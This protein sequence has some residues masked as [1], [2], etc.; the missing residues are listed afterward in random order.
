M[1]AKG[2]LSSM[3]NT[4]TILISSIIIGGSLI[5]S[6][7]IMK[8]LYPFENEHVITTTRGEVK[9]GDIYSENRLLTIRLSDSKNNEIFSMEN[10]NPDEYVKIIDDE[11][12]KQVRDYNSASPGNK[13][14]P[15]NMILKTNGILTITA[16]MEY[17]SEHIPSFT[18]TL[19]E[20]NSPIKKDSL[21]KNA[22][23]AAVSS[24][25][26]SEHEKY[27]ENSFIK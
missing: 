3:L 9:L 2:V 13:V 5:L 15:D 14:T 6:A 24:F 21:I 11:I 18:L 17:K 23:V 16:A 20:I 1:N 25:V 27:R 4:T 26:E 10:I 22:I 7:L 12:D 8:G 19:D